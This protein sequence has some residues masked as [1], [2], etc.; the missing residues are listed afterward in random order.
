[1][2]QRKNSLAWLVGGAQGSGVESS[3]T[4][5]ARACAAGGLHIYSQREYY[6]NIMGEH[7]YFQVRVDEKPIRSS[8]AT[9]DLIVSADAETVFIHARNANPNGGIIYDS[10]LV[11]TPISKVPMLEHHARE[12]IAHYLQATGLGETVGAMVKDAEKRGVRL[13]PVPYDEL[14]QKMAS[15]QMIQLAQGRR[16]ANAMA[17]AA[18][19]AVLNYEIK[20][21]EEALTEIFQGKKKIIDLNMKAVEITYDYVRKTFKNDFFVQLVPLATKETRLYV[22]GNQAVALGKIAA[23]CTV[24]TY[25]PISPATDESTYLEAHGVFPHTREAQE[26]SGAEKGSIL[27]IQTED[28]IAAITMA[29][30]ATLAGARAATSTSGPGFSLMV[31]ALGWAGINEVPVVVQLYQRGSPSTG[32]PTRHEQGDLRFVLHAG[33]GEFPRIVLASGDLEEC[34][35][36]AMRIFNYAERYQTPAIHLLDKALASSNQTLAPFKP[37]MVKIDRGALLGEREVMAKSSSD[38]FKRFEYTD[39][40]VSPRV[41]LGTKGGIFW[42]TGDEHDEYGHIIEDPTVRVQMMEK[43]AKKLELAAKEIPLSEKMNV[44]GDPRAETVILSWGST[45]GAILDA[46][47]MLKTEGINVC[48]VQVRLIQPLPSEELRQAVINAKRRL[49]I[50]NNFSGQFAG[51]VREHTGLMM[52]HLI[53]KYN[54]RPISMDEIVNAVKQTVKGKAPKKIVLT[55][56]E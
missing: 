16:I 5:F 55:E 35:Y 47:E 29:T 53:V 45:K 44:F 30:G 7:S 33:H 6:S 36:D 9:A 46:I 32:L 34:F 27:V 15:G 23:G 8:R 56:G 51:W 37:E 17:V 22:G 2:S 21:L 39:S 10:K 12:E 28:E 38:G 48:F 18:S 49:C 42:N 24:Q 41:G 26:V 54:G 3:A 4:L 20:K 11:D 13:Y 1:M 14:L 40:G 52:D 43:R 25:Y 31:E 50:E 19:F